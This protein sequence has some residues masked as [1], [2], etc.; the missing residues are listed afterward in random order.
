VLSI[1]QQFKELRV[2]RIFLGRI[3][4]KSEKMDEFNKSTS[5]FPFRPHITDKSR[6]LA[7]Q[8]KEKEHFHSVNHEIMEFQLQTER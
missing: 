7:K 1:Y 8:K 4:R 5:S 2:T 6:S 3:G